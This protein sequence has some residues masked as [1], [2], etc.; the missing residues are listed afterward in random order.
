LSI[1][2]KQPV[3]RLLQNANFPNFCVRK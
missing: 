2:F 1:T 3:D